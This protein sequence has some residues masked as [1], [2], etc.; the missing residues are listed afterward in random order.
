M[1]TEYIFMPQYGLFY[2][3]NWRLIIKVLR[4]AADQS[5]IAPVQL[6]ICILLDIISITLP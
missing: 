6:T 5:S 1:I 4:I 3:H 2:H